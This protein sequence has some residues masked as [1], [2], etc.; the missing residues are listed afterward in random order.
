M[1]YRTTIL[2]NKISKQELNEVIEGIHS[3]VEL[4]D[5]DFSVNIIARPIDKDSYW[6]DLLTPIIEEYEKREI[7]PVP[8]ILI[9]IKSENNRDGYIKELK[10]K[11]PGYL[12]YRERIEKLLLLV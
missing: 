11:S 5:D 9:F 10:E 4:I 1:A 12:K 7:D 2:S 8:N 3:I 6:M